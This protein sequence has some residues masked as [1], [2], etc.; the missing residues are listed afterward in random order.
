MFHRDWATFTFCRAVAAVN[1]GINRRGA[2]DIWDMMVVRYHEIVFEY[3]DR[4]ENQSKVSHHGSHV[5]SFVHKVL[6]METGGV[7]LTGRKRIRAH[8]FVKFR[9]F[10]RDLRDMSISIPKMSSRPACQIRI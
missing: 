7:I 4:E 8:V 3:R 10:S 5:S 2:D 9:Q 1:G 6:P